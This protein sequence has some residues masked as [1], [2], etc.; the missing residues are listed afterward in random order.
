MTESPVMSRRLT[1]AEATFALMHSDLGG[2]TQVVTHL[3]L[4]VVIPE[5][6]AKSAVD[7]WV[8]QSPLL[9]TQVRWHGS[10]LWLERRCMTQG[11]FSYEASGSPVDEDAIMHEELNRPVPSEDA[12]WR[13]RFVVAEVSGQTHIYFARSHAISDG[14]TT[15]HLMRDLAGRLVEAPPL[16]DPAVDITADGVRYSDLPL[17]RHEASGCATPPAPAPIALV[18]AEPAE[19]TSEFVSWTVASDE[20]GPSATRAKEQGLTINELLSSAFAM[21]TAE[22]LERHDIG[23]YTAVS[24]RRWL[25]PAAASAPGCTI[26]VVRHGVDT[27]GRPLEQVALDY[28]RQF[29]KALAAWR[30]PDRDHRQIQTDVRALLGHA[31][32]AGICITNVGSADPAF[33][34][35]AGQVVRYRTIVNRRAA[36]YAIVLHAGSL[37]GVFDLALSFGSP[38][39][40]A[41]AVKAVSDRMMKLLQDYGNGRSN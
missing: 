38:S 19:R 1:D 14:A 29:A 10:N 15:A 6:V 31:T 36:N 27:G 2:A 24:L 12:P 37:A 11:V 3:A 20:M 21:A 13:L 32:S 23:F 41:T 18:P 28:R 35:I 30:V 7:D 16:T 4:T 8:G 9:E 22:V 26:G 25:P 17:N 39:M 5:H 33:G 34:D 40:P